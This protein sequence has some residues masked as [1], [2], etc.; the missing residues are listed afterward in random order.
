MFEKKSLYFISPGTVAV[1]EEQIAAPGAGQV[2]V[3]STLSAISTGTEMLLYRGQFPD[4]LTLD[5]DIETLQG[6]LSYPLK[7][8]YS[9][10]GEVIEIG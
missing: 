1:R 9:L 5:E 8:G 4:D 2:L 7:Y 6:N 10:V 3:R